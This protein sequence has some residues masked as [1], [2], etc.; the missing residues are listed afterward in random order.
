MILVLGNVLVRQD[1]L[2][3]ALALCK[4]HSARSRAE[5]GC[6]RH[7]VHQDAENPLQLVFVEQWSDPDALQA[8]F[9]LPASKAFVAGLVPLATEPPGLTVYQAAPLAM[10]TRLERG[11]S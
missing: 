9:N 11:A 10:G 3:E 7:A 5:P 4:A 1:R 6:L 2:E 8:H